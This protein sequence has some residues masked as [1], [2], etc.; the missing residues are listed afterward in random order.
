MEDDPELNSAAAMKAKQKLKTVLKTIQ[1]QQQ[2]TAVSFD[3]TIHKQQ[4]QLPCRHQQQL[5]AASKQHVTC[6]YLMVP[7]PSAT[8]CLL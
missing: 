6:W 5:A 1:V 2:E 3:S 7:A 8:A 4:Q